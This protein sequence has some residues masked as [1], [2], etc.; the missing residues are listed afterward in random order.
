MLPFDHPLPSVLYELGQISATGK[1]YADLNI[2]SN[3]SKFRK[4]FKHRTIAW[5][6]LQQNPLLL[7]YILLEFIHGAAPLH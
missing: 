1:K 5:Y 2:I 6:S 7:K 3:K 4:Y